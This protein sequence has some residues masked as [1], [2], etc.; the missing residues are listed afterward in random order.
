[1]RMHYYLFFVVMIGGFVLLPAILKLFLKNGKFT[2]I[3]NSILIIPFIGIMLSLTLGR[4]SFGKYVEVEF[5]SAGGWCDKTIYLFQKFGI[6]DM[7]I[8]LAMLTPIGVFAWSFK[9]RFVKNILIS[10]FFGLLFGFTIE[11]LQFILPIARTVQIQD[12]LFNMLSSVIGGLFVCIC[13]LIFNKN[14][15]R[16]RVNEFEKV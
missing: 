16:G 15:K 2:K 8:N 10:A 7:I 4:V 6:R 1:M 14:N 12:I 5:V 13:A 3:F 9:R 11:S